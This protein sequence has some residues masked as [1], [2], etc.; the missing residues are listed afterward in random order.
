[1]RA[2]KAELCV[3]FGARNTADLAEHMTLLTEAVEKEPE[4]TSAMM[5]VLKTYLSFVT[6]SM[7]RA[8]EQ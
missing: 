2:C 6:T 8:A 3:I 4:E 5:D 7:I 1:M